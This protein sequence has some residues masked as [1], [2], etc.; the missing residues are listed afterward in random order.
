LLVDKFV[1]ESSRRASFS[2]LSLFLFLLS[3]LYFGLGWARPSPY[4]LYNLYNLCNLYNL[5]HI[6][7]SL[8]LWQV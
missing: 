8:S 1:Y 7:K 5:Y 6:Y 2:V 4:N 3:S